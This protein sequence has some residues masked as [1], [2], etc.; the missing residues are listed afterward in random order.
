MIFGERIRKERMEAGVGLNELCRKVKISSSY[1]SKIER[2][3]ETHAPSEEVVT[4]LASVLGLDVSEMLLLAGK[5]P[6]DV[7]AAILADAAMPEL[8]RELRKRAMSAREVL[9][10]LPPIDRNPP[11]L[12]GMRDGVMT[13]EY[14][15]KQN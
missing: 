1:L 11:P 15:S 12:V 8:I 7:K 3:I 6:S 4:A 5:I 10:G 9:A 14:P 2:G 13:V